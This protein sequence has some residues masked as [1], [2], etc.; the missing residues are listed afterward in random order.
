MKFEIV[1]LYYLAMPQVHDITDGSQDALLV[2][3]RAG[4]HTGPGRH[5]KRRGD[6][7]NTSWIRKSKLPVR[8]C[9]PRRMPATCNDTNSLTTASRLAPDPG[10][11]RDKECAGSRQTPRTVYPCTSPAPVGR[12]GWPHGMGIVGVTA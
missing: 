2:R 7:K 3:V 5:P 6:S 10:M 11:P 12:S 9:M 4:G 1:D 8:L